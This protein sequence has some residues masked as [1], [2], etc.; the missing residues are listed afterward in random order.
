MS[1][2]DRFKGFFSD[3]KTFHVGTIG[4]DIRNPRNIELINDLYQFALEK[5]SIDYDLTLDALDK[6]RDAIFE[7]ANKYNVNAFEE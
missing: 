1:R 3:V 2:R 6:N 5:I 7:I 4:G